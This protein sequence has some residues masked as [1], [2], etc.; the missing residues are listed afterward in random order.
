MRNKLSRRDFAKARFAAGATGVFNSRKEYWFH[1]FHHAFFPQSFDFDG[2]VKTPKTTTVD[3]RLEPEKKKGNMRLCADGITPAEFFPACVYVNPVKAISLNALGLSN[4]GSQKVFEKGILQESGE[5]LIFSFSAVRETLAERMEETLEYKRLLGYFLPGF[6]HPVEG[7]INRSCPN[8]G[9]HGHPIDPFLV[10]RYDE[11][12]LEF[13]RETWL[14]LDILAPLGIN[15]DVKLSVATSPL[16]AAEIVKHPSKPGISIPNTLAYGRFSSKIDWEGIFGS[17]ESPLKHLGGG[18]F[19]GP[20]LT[21]LVLEWLY[22]FRDVDSDTFVGAG[23]IFHPRDV[24]LYKKAGANAGVLGTVLMHRPWRVQ[25][26]I[27][28]CNKTF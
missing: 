1:R 12:D 7:Q 27:Q 9:L 19:S 11:Y 25:A 23:S 28:E 17:R 4:P 6:P 16:T 20:Q 13:V 26:I 14:M 5:R 15:W 24:P 18:G 21:R 2:A 3:A 8:V 22:D 10:R